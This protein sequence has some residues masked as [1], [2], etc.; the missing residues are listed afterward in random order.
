MFV[1]DKRNFLS[2]HKGFRRAWFSKPIKMTKRSIILKEH[3]VKCL[4]WFSTYICIYMS[5]PSY[6]VQAV[7]DFG[8]IVAVLSWFL[9]FRLLFEALFDGNRTLN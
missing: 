6:F 5:N 3:H 7:S 2:R 4:I 8:A 1:G 9:S